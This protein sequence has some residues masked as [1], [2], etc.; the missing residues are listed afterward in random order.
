VS[1]HSEGVVLM[2]PSVISMFNNEG[3]SSTRGWWILWKE[4]MFNTQVK[5]Q[6]LT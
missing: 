1:V 4:F 2:R 6:K 3:L 5:V